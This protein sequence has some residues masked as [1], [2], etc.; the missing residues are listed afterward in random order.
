[1]TG[2]PETSQ[3]RTI[4]EHAEAL[5]DASAEEVLATLIALAPLPDEDS[6]EWDDARTWDEARRFVALADAAAARRLTAAIPLLLERAS[7]GDPGE[8]MRGLRH[9]LEAIV[10]P[11]WDVLATRCIALAASERFGTRLWALDQL[12][13]LKDERARPA[14]EAA[15]A[16]PIPEFRDLAARGLWHLDQPREGGL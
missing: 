2:L 13:G 6:T 1:M 4:T 3:H 14:F 12:V 9:R 5:T 8:M 16:S 11:D 10:N 15:H 7:F